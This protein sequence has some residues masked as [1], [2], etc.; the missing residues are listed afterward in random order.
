[1]HPIP[2]ESGAFFQIE[3]K[4]EENK[5]RTVQMSNLLLFGLKVTT[6]KKIP[7]IQAPQKTKKIDKNQRLLV[8][9]PGHH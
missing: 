6:G 5:P 8:Q 9:H 3:M 2:K 7:C 4:Q 1:M